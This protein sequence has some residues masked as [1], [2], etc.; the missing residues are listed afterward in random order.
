M[1]VFTCIDM[2]GFLLSQVV[3]I[4]CDIC[5]KK[6]VVT[7][8]KHNTKDFSERF[9]GYGRSEVH[10]LLPA[11]NK[12][13]FCEKGFAKL[14]WLRV[15]WKKRLFAYPRVGYSCIKKMIILSTWFV[16]P[17]FGMLEISLKTNWKTRFPLIIL[18]FVNENALQQH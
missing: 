15:K 14:S 10:E 6:S 17:D 12:P 2:Y 11:F 1:L 4:S 13:W 7:L 5:A 16:K 18:H 9:I 8:L 3:T